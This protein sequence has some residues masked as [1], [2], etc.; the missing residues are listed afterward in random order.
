MSDW[1]GCSK[2]FKSFD[3]LY[4]GRYGCRACQRTEP[5]DGAFVDLTRPLGPILTRKPRP[6]YSP[7]RGNKPDVVE[8]SE[9]PLEIP[10]R[11]DGGSAGHLLL[12][13]R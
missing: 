6:S 1:R 13:S 3:G 4:R 2:C 10:L 12:R 7:F 8:T 9:N 5:I 11:H